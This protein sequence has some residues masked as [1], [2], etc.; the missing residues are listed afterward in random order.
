MFKKASVMKFNNA[1][2]L[3]SGLQVSE[4]LNKLFQ[5]CSSLRPSE[6]RQEA[7][8]PKSRRMI[9]KSQ[10]PF[11]IMHLFVSAFEPHRC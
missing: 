5:T 6:K 8:Q 11:F 3:I 10:T 4:N 2:G 7:D 1:A 9:S